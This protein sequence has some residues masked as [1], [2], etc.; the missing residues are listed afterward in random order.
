MALTRTRSVFLAAGALVVVGGVT[1]GMIQRL[2]PKQLGEQPDSSVLVPS[3]QVLTPVGTLRKTEGARP[4]DLA[5]SPDGK[6]VAVLTT[7]RV[8]LYGSGGEEL[9]TVALSAGPLGL[10]WSPESTVLYASGSN[11]RVYRL[12]PV[13]GKWAAGGNFPLETQAETAEARRAGQPA[14]P[15]ATGMAV[16]ADGRR[17]F[18][19]LGIRNAVAV[20]GLPEMN[21]LQK[22]KVGAAP[23]SLALSGDGS[24]LVTAN[25]G[26]EVMAP[27]ADQTADSAGTRVRVD[28]KTDAALRGSLTF[29]DTKTLAPLEMPAGRQ[30]AGMALTRDGRTLYAANSDGDSVSEVD[31]RARRIRRTFSIRPPEDPGFGQIP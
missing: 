28:P 31:V 29:I 14:N 6:T 17:L 25:R 5:L 10:A 30:P 16:S 2:A 11:G 27:D 22:V 24:V 9:G 26:G 20:L 3:N 7:T 19:G 12:E 15:Q 8:M 4:K 21:V 18:V 23:Y 13:N 1:A